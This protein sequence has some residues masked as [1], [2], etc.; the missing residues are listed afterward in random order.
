M[1]HEEHLQDAAKEM[2]GS[3]KKRNFGCVMWFDRPEDPDNWMWWLT[4]TRD[5]NLLERSNSKV[6]RKE[7]RAEGFEDDVR[8]ER[9]NH[10]ACGWAEA[11]CIRVYDADGEVTPAFR[12]A[13][14]LKEELEACP[15]LDEDDVNK[16]K[17]EEQLRCIR[18]NGKVDEDLACSACSSKSGKWEK[19]VWEW[20]W[21]NDQQA[22]ESDDNGWVDEGSINKA[23][24]HLGWLDVE[25]FLLRDVLMDDFRLQ[26]FD[27][28]IRKP[29]LG[30]PYGRAYLGYRLYLPDGTLLFEGTDYSPGAFKERG[31]DSD[32]VLRPLVGWLTMVPGEDDGDFSEYTKEQLFFAHTDAQTISLWADEEGPEFR[33]AV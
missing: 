27:I 32:K 12:R 11:V 8:I 23:L 29:A 13:Y 6:I 1:T 7:M 14:E 17:R 3:W 25:D 31:L 16:R 9:H 21:D 19:D 22:F 10:W 4:K 18:E 2:A 33:E 28:G 24:M 20:L 30:Y 5:S 15:I 26:L